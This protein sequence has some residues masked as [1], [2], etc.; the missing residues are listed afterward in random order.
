MAKKKTTPFTS[1]PAPGVISPALTAGRVVL[2]A[3]PMTDGSECLRPARAIVA[4]NPTCGD[5]VVDLDPFADAFATKAVAKNPKQPEKTERSREGIDEGALNAAGALVT[6]DR[7][8]RLLSLH[9]AS[10][11]EGTSAGQFRWP[12]RG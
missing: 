5:L 2:F 4:H 3:L 6:T 1:S 8:G 7:N 12:T 11:I 9:V 10:A